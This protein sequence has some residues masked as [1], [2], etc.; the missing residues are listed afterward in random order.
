MQLKPSLLAAAALLATGARASSVAYDVC[1]TA[2]CN[3]VA[4]ACYAG[5]SFAFGTFTAGLGVPP[6][7]VACQTT[8]EKCSSACA[9]LFPST[10]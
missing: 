1:Q 3:T 7:L 5:A 2:G 8:L 6:A 10:P 4:V 9:S